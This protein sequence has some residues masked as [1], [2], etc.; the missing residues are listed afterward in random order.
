MPPFHP[1][2]SS[3][4][5]LGR[6]A[7]NL[8]RNGPSMAAPVPRLTRR[9]LVTEAKGK[10]PMIALEEHYIAKSAGEPEALSRA[11]YSH[12]PASV[13]EKLFDLDT[14]RIPAMDAG[15]I[16]LQVL[17]HVPADASAEVCAK[18]N[19]EVAGA[20]KRNPDRYAAFAMLPMS[21]PPAAVKEL[22]RCVADLGM[23]GAMID[24][25]LT[26]GTYYDGAEFWPVFEV[27]ERLDVPLYI[28]PAIQPE[29]RRKAF[30]GNYSKEVQMAL[31]HWGFGWHAATATHVLRLFAAGVFD[32]YS[33][34]KVVVGH[35]GE[36]L[37]FTLE[38]TDRLS[39]TWGPKKK[40]LKQVWNEN[41]WVTTSGM[42]SVNP[43]A[44]VLRNTPLDH[45]MYSVDYP[46]EQNEKGLKFMEDLKESGLVTEEQFKAIACRNAAKLLKINTPVV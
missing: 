23:V 43:M 16:S 32:Q 1:S 42:F 33:K 31:A 26:D 14:Q 28:H 21:D 25:H 19:E 17:S 29:E 2:S 37:P 8:Y 18:A 7:R 45:I 40:G 20:V 34:L 36:L 24:N 12:F 44:T 30:A 10:Y 3:M 4:R 13:T 27:A 6:L 38:R 15:S 35:M 5:Q 46:F 9:N 41:I 22:E 39:K 11:M